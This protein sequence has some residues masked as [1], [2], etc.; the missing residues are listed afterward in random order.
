MLAGVVALI[1]A[2]SAPAADGNGMQIRFNAADQAAARA[3]VLQKIDFQGAG[4]E[5][6]ARQPDLSPP[7]TC[8]NYNPKQSDLVL[9][10]AAETAFSQSALTFDS[11][12]EVMK[13]ARMVRLDWQRSMLSPGL[14]PCLLHTLTRSAPK[15]T[16]IASLAKLP[17]PHVGTSSSAFR[18]VTVARSAKNPTVRERVVIDFVVIARGRVE[19]VLTTVAPYATRKAVKN[20]EVHL[21]RVLASRAKA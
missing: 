3:I 14:L 15:G 4:W 21:A 16:T 20:A 9:T 13:T 12:V 6:G 11:E 1:G 18:L 19:I 2:A 8:P 5:G 17:F 7:P 10:G